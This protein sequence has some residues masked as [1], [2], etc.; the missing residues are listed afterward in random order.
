VQRSLGNSC[1]LRELTATLTFTGKEAE[2]TIL[3]TFSHRDMGGVAYLIESTRV[4]QNPD[5]NERLYGL[6]RV[7]SLRRAYGPGAVTAEDLDKCANPKASPILL[8]ALPTLF[9]STRK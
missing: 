7:E 5:E 9:V 4:P 8:E 2:F 1:V 6:K 3:Y